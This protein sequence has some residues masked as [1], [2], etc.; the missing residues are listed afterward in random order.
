MEGE[1]EGEG[2]R[3]G[4]RE[5]RGSTG[6]RGLHPDG[7]TIMYITQCLHYCPA[8]T[9]AHRTINTSHIKL[10]QVHMPPTLY[11]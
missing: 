10:F 11:I 5:D 2:Q 1:R 9:T 8:F 6:E 3:E 7:H 4:E